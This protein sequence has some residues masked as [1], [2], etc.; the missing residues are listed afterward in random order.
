MTYRTGNHWGVTIVREGTG[1]TDPQ[2]RRTGDQL[3]AVVVNG[4]QTLAERICEL[5]NGET[6]GGRRSRLGDLIVMHGPY[7]AYELIPNPVTRYLESTE[8]NA[9]R[10][11]LIELRGIQTDREDAPAGPK[12][13]ECKL[14]REHNPQTDPCDCR[15][16]QFCAMGHS[17]DDAPGTGLS[18]PVSVQ[19]APVGGI[20]RPG[21]SEA[22]SGRFQVEG[23]GLYGASGDLSLR[24]DRC[25]WTL[26]TSARLTLAELNQRADEHTGVCR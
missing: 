5:L 10:D 22:I 14:S 16:S 19:E 6:P 1:P 7:E 21:G 24:C 15:V 25:P 4:D 17:I 2:G 9:L 13:W 12:P 3:V 23:I 20:G 18:A 26:H 11:E 8:L